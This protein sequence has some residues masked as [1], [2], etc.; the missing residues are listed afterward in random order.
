MARLS[1]G[2]REGLHLFEPRDALGRSS[3]ERPGEQLAIDV[4]REAL[5]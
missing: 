3:G 2:V 4:A 1:R 5:G